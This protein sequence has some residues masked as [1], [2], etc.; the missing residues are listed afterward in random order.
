[1][2]DSPLPHTAL[3]DVAA[4]LQRPRSITLL[5]GESGSGKISVRGLVTPGCYAGD[6]SRI[7]IALVDLAPDARWPLAE[8]VP[9][10]QS[11]GRR[12][13]FHPDAL[14]RGDALLR[15]SQDCDLLVIDEIGP[16]ELIDHGGWTS[17]LDVLKEGRYRQAL[18]VIRPGLLDT[19]IGLL[20][21]MPVHTIYVA[22]ETGS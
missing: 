4:W 18:V 2:T 21:G 13:R 7:A 6:G 1:V 3:L 5:T 14:I 16:L 22:G 8:R 9:P 15:A 12:W 10:E 17:A 20:P 19:L 11:T